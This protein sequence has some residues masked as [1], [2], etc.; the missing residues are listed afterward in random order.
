MAEGEQT[1][2][3]TLLEAIRLYRKEIKITRR[4]EELPEITPQERDT[5]RL[6]Q[7]F[8]IKRHHKESTPEDRS[9]MM[10]NVANERWGNKT[11]PKR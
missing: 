6:V 10:R 2:Q 11:K 7:K 8:F 4:F 5:W 1:L 3:A 9:E